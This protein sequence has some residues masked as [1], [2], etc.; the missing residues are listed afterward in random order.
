M[1]SPAIEEI[2]NLGFYAGSKNTSKNCRLQYTSYHNRNFIRNCSQ[3]YIL[4]F[5]MFCCLSNVLLL[6]VLVKDVNGILHL[7]NCKFPIILKQLIYDVFFSDRQVPSI[8]LSNIHD[9]SN[10]NVFFKQHKN[11]LRKWNCKILHNDALNIIF[12]KE[13]FRS[14]W[15]PSWSYWRSQDSFG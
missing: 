3:M 4:L 8:L 13:S 7:C 11:E 10:D 14:R 2:R 6:S 1:D 15:K 9:F 12:R 5:Q